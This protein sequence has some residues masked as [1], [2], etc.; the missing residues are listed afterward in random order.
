MFLLTLGSLW[1]FLYNL[2]YFM[3]YKTVNPRNSSKTLKLTKLW[4]KKHTHQRL[5]PD[6]QARNLRK[7]TARGRHSAQP[8]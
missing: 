6:I 3:R 8:R 4:S 1:C 7:F 5:Q 2:Y